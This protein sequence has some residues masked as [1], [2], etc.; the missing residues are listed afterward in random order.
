MWPPCTSSCESVLSTFPLSGGLA[1]SWISRNICRPYT[2]Y[3]VK[4][5]PFFHIVSFGTY[6]KLFLPNIE[7]SFLAGI[8][9]VDAI[10]PVTH[11]ISTQHSYSMRQA[12]LPPFL[13]TCNSFPF[14]GLRITSVH[15][16]SALLLTDRRKKI[17]ENCLSPVK[18]RLYIGLTERAIQLL[19]TLSWS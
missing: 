13:F 18:N 11:T 7:H 5:I 4:H 1:V 8:R 16:A 19:C 14:S 3:K 15:S 12:V 9:Q 17:Y 6:C 10:M 2:H